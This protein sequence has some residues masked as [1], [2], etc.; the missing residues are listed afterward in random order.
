MKGTGGSD[1]HI[2]SQVGCC[3]TV[4]E[5]IIRGEEDLVAAIKGGRFRALDRRRSEQKSPAYWFSR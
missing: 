3:V 4:F 1:A 2:P 5:D